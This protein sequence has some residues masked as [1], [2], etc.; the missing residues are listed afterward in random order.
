[1]AC[2]PHSELSTAL[3][4]A[5]TATSKRIKGP[6]AITRAPVVRGFLVSGIALD[7]QAT[8]DVVQK[9]IGFGGKGPRPRSA[10]ARPE[11]KRRTGELR[12]LRLTQKMTFLA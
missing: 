4:H 3:P 10:L 5:E 12:F 8:G 1:M 6:Q 7:M 2:T 11:V 9:K